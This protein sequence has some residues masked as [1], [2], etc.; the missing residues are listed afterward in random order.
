[1]SLLGRVLGWLSGRCTKQLQDTGDIVWLF[2]LK[3]SWVAQAMYVAIQ[4]GI[5]DHLAAVSIQEDRH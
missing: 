4:L 1:V 2:A 5:P 3:S